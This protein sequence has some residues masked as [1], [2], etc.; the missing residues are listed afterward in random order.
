MLPIIVANTVLQLVLTFIM[1]N[2][3]DWRHIVFFGAF[4]LLI[5]VITTIV[6]LLNIFYLLQKIYNK[7]NSNNEPTI[8]EPKYKK[9]IKIDKKDEEIPEVFDDTNL[10]N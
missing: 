5:S 8:E 3:L 1:P 6:V 7:K 4:I 9:L 2:L 10:I